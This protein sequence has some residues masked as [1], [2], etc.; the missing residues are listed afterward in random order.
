MF[1]CF[2][3]ISIDRFHIFILFYYDIN[4][5]INVLNLFCLLF[6]QVVDYL[7]NIYSVLLTMLLKV[8]ELE[9]IHKLRNGNIALVF[10]KEIEGGVEHV[11]C[12]LYYSLKFHKCN[13]IRRNL[14][15][16]QV[17]SCVWFCGDNFAG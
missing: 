9:T 11:C 8:I 6:C 15:Y 10:I 12:G 13:K 7:Y 1:T 14:L 2:G 17:W 3:I 16:P 5:A 4:Q